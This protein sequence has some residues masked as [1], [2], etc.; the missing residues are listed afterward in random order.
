MANWSKYRS[1]PFYMFSAPMFKPDDDP[2]S[3]LQFAT[4]N[5]QD[6]ISLMIKNIF[7]ALLQPLFEIFKL[8]TDALTQSISGLFNMRG[9]FDLMWKKWTSMAD[10]F[11]R[12]FHGVFHN[13]RLTFTKIYHS[14]EKSYAIAMASVYA[15]ISTIHTMTSFLDLILKIVITILIIIVAMVILLFFV[16]AP[17]IPLILTVIGVVAATAMG[18]AVGGMAGAFCFTGDSRILTPDGL[19]RIDQIKVGQTLSATN[20]VTGVLKFISNKY[21]L[22]YLDGIAV[23]GTHIVFYKNKPIHVKDH[24]NAYQL[25]SAFEKLYCLIT[26]EHTIP[27]VGDLETHIFA[28]WEEL[29]TDEE[30]KSWYAEVYEHLN[31]TRATAAPSED[32]INSESAVAEGTFIATQYG[33]TPIERLIPGHLVF[34]AD[35]SL[36]KVLGIVKLDSLSVQSVAKYGDTT[37][38]S[39]SWVLD[40]NTWDHPIPTEEAPRN[41]TWYSLFT[42]KGT[43]RVETSEGILSMRDFSDIGNDEIHTTY[44]SVLRMMGERT[45][46]QNDE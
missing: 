2:R 34:A 20:Q 32:V 42:D 11:T 19:I 29:E 30:L 15:G 16:L 46:F 7:I 31:G 25:P 40:N 13:F 1:D 38:S 6:V 41:K 12:R 43:F 28:D 37:I 33:P 21:D 18:G 35:G 27:I 44:E 26:S 23:S 36:A 17:T 8:I 10:I 5:F 22:Y 39:G 45:F 24:P 3:R 4:D 9:M 14:M